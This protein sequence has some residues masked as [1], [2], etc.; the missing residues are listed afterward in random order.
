LHFWRVVVWTNPL[1]FDKI[2]RN[3]FGQRSWPG[4][5]AAGGGRVSWMRRAYP[6]L[7]ARKCKRPFWGRLHFWRVVV[8]TNPLG[9]DK[10]V[11]ND[12]G[13]RSWPGA[14]TA[15]GGRVS[16]M[17]RAYPTLSARK[18][19]RPLLGPFAFLESG[20]VDEPAWVRAGCSQRTTSLCALP[21][22]GNQ[23]RRA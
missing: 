13:Q 12:F 1:G 10:I 5:R 2:V 16:W 15:G 8:W 3:D 23:R 4:A 14:R 7:S 21:H 18:C 6:T 20:G 19:K 11:R 22:G 17:R 9:F